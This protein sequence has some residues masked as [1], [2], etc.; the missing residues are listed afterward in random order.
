MDD[1]WKV[2]LGS[3]TISVLSYAGVDFLLRMWISTR[4]KKSIQHEYDIKLESFK[5]L[6]KL[7][8]ETYKASYSR[9]LDENHIRFEWWYE[10]QA[11]ALQEIYELIVE[12]EKD[13]THYFDIE[14]NNATLLAQDAT[15]ILRRYS[16]RYYR[17]KTLQILIPDDIMPDINEIFNVLGNIVK[18]KR[19]KGNS[20][21]DRIQELATQN[22]YNENHFNFILAQIRKKVNSLLCPLMAKEEPKMSKRQLPVDSCGG[23]DD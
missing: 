5:A 18:I 16:E 3:A 12:S 7:E 1:L 19:S 20:D 17:Y 8:L 4:L 14:N 10:R 21:F 6:Q 11:T 9:F 23:T 2:M 15:N 13:Y 22:F